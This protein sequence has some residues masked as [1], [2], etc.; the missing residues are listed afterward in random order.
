M[1]DL[2]RLQTRGGEEGCVIPETIE[3]LVNVY[4]EGG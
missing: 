4:E 3:E 1:Y 2:K